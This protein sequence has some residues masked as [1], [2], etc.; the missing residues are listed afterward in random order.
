MKILLAKWMPNWHNRLTY[1]WLWK[2]WMLRCNVIINL[3]CIWI[4]LELRLYILEIVIENQY[5]TESWLFQRWIYTY[6]LFTDDNYTTIYYFHISNPPALNL[7]FILLRPLPFP[8]LIEKTC[9]ISF[10]NYL[11]HFLHYRGE[12]D[13]R[14]DLFS[15]L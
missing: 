15:T 4:S 8:R 14:S 12:D 7:S 11:N 9:V 13:L 5:L 10:N 6:L 3:D 1:F 2:T